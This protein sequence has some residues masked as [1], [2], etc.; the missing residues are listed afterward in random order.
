MDVIYVPVKESEVTVIRSVNAAAVLRAAD[1]VT[2]LTIASEYTVNL[3]PVAE[4]AG[5][6]YVVKVVSFTS[7]A[8]TLVVNTADLVKVIRKTGANGE[9]DSLTFNAAVEYA[10]L[11]SNGD[12]WFILISNTYA[13]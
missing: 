4:C 8:V 10:V 9:V 12:S 1:R 13:A 7:D 2:E 3:P 5:H 11:Y 6:I